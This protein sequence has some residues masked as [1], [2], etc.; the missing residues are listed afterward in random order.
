MSCSIGLKSYRIRRVKLTWGED[1]P[2]PRRDFLQGALIGAAC[3]LTGP[4]LRPPVAQAAAADL[5]GYS[6]PIRTGLRGS[7]PG[8]FEQAHAL[9]DGAGLGSVTE[10]GEA[11]DLVVVG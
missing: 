1:R 9:R 8:S 11:Y 10:T 5:P 7:Q 2:I 6:P 4:L 3:A